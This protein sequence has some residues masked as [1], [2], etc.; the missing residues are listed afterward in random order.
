MSH[1]VTETLVTLGRRYVRHGPGHL[2]KAALA[3]RY[4]NPQ[5]RD[6]PRRSVVETRYGARFAVDTQDLIQRYLYLFG[7][8]EPHM[9]S[10]LRNRLRPGDGFIDVGANIGYFSV[11]ASQ[12]VGRTGR[13]VAVEASPVYHARIM[14]NAR[15]NADVDIR[16]VN[17]A[18]SD[19]DETLTFVLA[20]SHNMGAASIVPYEGDAEARFEVAARPLP[21][22]LESDEISRARV[23]KVDV[24]GAEGGVVR[25][26]VPM[27]AR[28]RPDAEITV[29]VTP[30][31]MTRLGESADEL[32]ET[33]RGAGFHTYRLPNSY[34]AESYPWALR[35]AWPGAVRWRG[36]VREES[37]LVFSRV[38]A[39]YLR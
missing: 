25:G 32:V 31:R 18:V 4:L 24:E 9:T 6:A 26:M 7:V 21:S 33:L 37:D 27:L 19:K 36:A 12:L 8:W 30:E 29:E 23:I 34:A 20:S 10:W 1:F 35:E 15:L 16:V 2:G 39:E 5:L 3:A 14:Q 38:D 11:L 28:L 22:L 17:T 13:V